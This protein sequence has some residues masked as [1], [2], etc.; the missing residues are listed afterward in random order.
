MAEALDDM[1]FMVV[2]LTSGTEIGTSSYSFRV[3]RILNA[4]LGQTSIGTGTTGTNGVAISNTSMY[5][6]QKIL[7]KSDA[8]DDV[9]FLFSRASSTSF[10]IRV[11]HQPT[12]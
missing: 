4:G 3:S 12:V 11:I 2:S 6:D 10:R 9:Y 7:Q 1:H 8:S 5:F